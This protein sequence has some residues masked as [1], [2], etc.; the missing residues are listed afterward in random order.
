[1]AKP[2]S[3]IQRFL[4]LIIKKADYKG[5][6]K[7]TQLRGFIPLNPNPKNTIYIR[8]G[9]LRRHGYLRHLTSGG[10]GIPGVYKVKVKALEG[11]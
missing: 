1:M 9:H 8:L 6:V 2:M 4:R 10:G 11:L 7:T 3:D 5:V